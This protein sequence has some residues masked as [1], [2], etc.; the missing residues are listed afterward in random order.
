MACSKTLAGIGFECK[1]AVGG[2]VE[3]YIADI[4]DVTTITTTSDKVTAITMANDKKYKTYKFRKQTG[5]VNSTINTDVNAGTT[6]YQTDV[7]L[8]FTKMETSKRV[9]I[10]ALA[11][12]QVSI[13]VKDSMG[14]YWLVGTKDSPAELTAGTA[15]T[16]TAM[17]D[18]N[19]YNITLSEMGKALP[20]EVDKDVITPTIISQ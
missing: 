19:G 4:N 3:A 7:V 12:E 5:S 11:T 13:I 15:A 8:Q 14:M 10:S 18:L 9:E 17:G 6:W 1:D 16:G 2:I 20:L